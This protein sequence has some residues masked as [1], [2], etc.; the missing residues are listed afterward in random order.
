MEKVDV[1]LKKIKLEELLK[2]A[3]ETKTEITVTIEPDR[4]EIQVQPWKPF[5]YKCPAAPLNAEELMSRPDP[6]EKTVI[7]A[8]GTKLWTQVVYLALDKK[9]SF[10]DMLRELTEKGME[11]GKAPHG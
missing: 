9:I 2:Q 11:M 10:S 1:D 5:E 4:Q 6:G 3:A 8:L 7:D